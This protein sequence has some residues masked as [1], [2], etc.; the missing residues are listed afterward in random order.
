MI[1]KTHLRLGTW[2]HKGMGIEIK[3]DRNVKIILRPGIEPGPTEW[4]S[5]ILPLN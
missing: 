1:N 5:A 2:W 4:E 3:E